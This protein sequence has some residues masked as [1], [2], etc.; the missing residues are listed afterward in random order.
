[1][2]NILSVLLLFFGAL[3]GFGQVSFSPGK[4]QFVGNGETQVEVDVEVTN[5]YSETRTF[6]WKFTPAADYPSDWTIQICDPNL[7]YAPNVM[8]GSPNAG[9][10]LESGQTKK[11]SLK[12]WVNGGTVTETSSGVLCLFNDGDLSDKEGCTSEVVSGLTDVDAAIISIFPNP[13][14]DVFRIHGDAHVKQIEIYNIVGRKVKS[15][16]HVPNQSHDISDLRSGMYLVRL[17]DIHGNLL[18]TM[19]LS[20]Q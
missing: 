1:M 3:S 12:V 8:E 10:V 15:L 7:C 14:N 9:V 2:K 19:R 13:T 4:I 16:S 5:E 11:F 6:F 20:K 17:N 18:K